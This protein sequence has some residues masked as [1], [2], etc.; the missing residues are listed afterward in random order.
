MILELQVTVITCY[1]SGLWSLKFDELGMKWDLGTKEEDF[2]VEE[3][4]LSS[5]TMKMFVMGCARSKFL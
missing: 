5:L 4:F 3:E 2:K 1:K